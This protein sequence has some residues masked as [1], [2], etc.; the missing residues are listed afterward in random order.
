MFFLFYPNK[1]RRIAMIFC[2]YYITRFHSGQVVFLSNLA[3]R[4][5]GHFLNP[6]RKCRPAAEFVELWHLQKQKRM[7][8]YIKFGFLNGRAVA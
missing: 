7:I 5:C 3:P 8:K 4:R 6:D 2:S 1:L